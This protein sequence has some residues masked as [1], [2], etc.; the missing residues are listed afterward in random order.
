[1]L[2]GK[3]WKDFQSCSNSFGTNLDL[4][5]AFANFCDLKTVMASSMFASITGVN[6][7]FLGNFFAFL[8]DKKLKKVVVKFLLYFHFNLSLGFGDI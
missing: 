7:P 2:A 3:D 5:F 6:W 1:M 8:A 4:G